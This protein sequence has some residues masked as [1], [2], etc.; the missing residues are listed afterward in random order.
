MTSGKDC[1]NIF[2]KYELQLTERS[3]EGYKYDFATSTPIKPVPAIRKS[4]VNKG[5]NIN[6]ERLAMGKTNT[7]STIH[8]T[9]ENIS[10]PLDSDNEFCGNVSNKSRNHEVLDRSVMRL[11]GEV[12][13]EHGSPR[14]EGDASLQLNV[15][16][17]LANQDAYMEESTQGNACDMDIASS[18]ESTDS[19][20]KGPKNRLKP[21]N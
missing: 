12:G 21:L 8:S 2:S 10:S 16:E 15:I 4:V 17:N 6:T 20:I 18:L 11:K 13:S 5:F 1:S 19:K 7:A 9:N 14:K 3:N